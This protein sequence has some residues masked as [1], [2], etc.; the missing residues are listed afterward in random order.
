MELSAAPAS[1]LLSIDLKEQLHGQSPRLRRGPVP[2]AA[3]Q[4][5]EIDDVFA[6]LDEIMS[7]A[8]ASQTSRG[9]SAPKRTSSSAHD[10]QYA[11]AAAAALRGSL[12]QKQLSL[13][14]RPSDA[15]DSSVASTAP[16]DDETPDLEIAPKPRHKRDLPLKL[17]AHVSRA[18]NAFH[19]DDVDHL[20]DHLDSAR[21]GVSDVLNSAGTCNTEISQMITPRAQPGSGGSSNGPPQKP[22]ELTEEAS[23]SAVNWLCTAADQPLGQ[24]DED[25]EAELEMLREQQEMIEQL[26]K[27]KAEAFLAR[28]KEKYEEKLREREQMQ[29]MRIEQLQLIRLQE[30]R[31]KDGR[32]KRPVT[33]PARR[34]P[35]RQADGAVR[36]ACDDD[37]L[38]MSGCTETLSPGVTQRAWVCQG[39]VHGHSA[40]DSR[41]G[42]S[43]VLAWES[44]E[45]RVYTPKREDAASQRAEGETARGR[46][47]CSAI[48][49]AGEGQG[50]RGDMQQG[51]LAATPRPKSALSRL[52]SSF[53]SK[54][55]RAQV[56]PMSK[57]L[58]SRLGAKR[59]QPVS[60]SSD[61]I[62]IVPNRDDNSGSEDDM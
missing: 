22:R 21:T 16:S 26:C 61:G 9:S 18:S 27:I 4:V 11:P 33:A 50:Q 15:S 17:P 10:S 55:F 32:E 57:S 37:A 59:S 51:R 39:A 45:R 36:R 30:A 44:P 47:P 34:I 56:A 24:I 52:M 58:L 3:A 62:P 1:R 28:E 19:G 41:A 54:R 29:L 53:G 14:R 40:H 23:T 25:T 31:K 13:Q 5:D 7:G 38:N 20:L 2:V 46:R 35:V 49:E 60:W 6:A 12:F 43:G 48:A 8:D 42:D